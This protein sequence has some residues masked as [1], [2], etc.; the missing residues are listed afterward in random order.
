MRKISGLIKSPG[1]GKTIKLF[2]EGMFAF[3]LK[4]EIVLKERLEIGMEL[5]E[6]RIT[7][8]QESDRY[9][10]CL[11]TALRLLN[12][13]PRSEHEITI[14]LQQ[15]GFKE[16]D[17]QSVLSN[18]KKQGFIDDG[19]FAR[20]WK[21]NRQSFNPRSRRMTETELRQKG[22]SLDVI[23]QEVSDIDDAANAYRAALKYA[24]NLNTADYPGFRRRLG[25][26]L[27]RRGFGYDVINTTVTRLWNEKEGGE[28]VDFPDARLMSERY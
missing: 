2:L 17:I 24:R 11:D 3:S 5:S 21:D 22:V 19:N 10:K 7:S 16:N 13:R 18:L 12:Y 27:R 26:Y 6:L 23:E 4:E 20:F 25:E 9:Q 8:L 14:R 1:G 28:T 15:R